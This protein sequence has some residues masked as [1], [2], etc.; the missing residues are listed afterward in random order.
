MLGFDNLSNWV[1]VPP[2]GTRLSFDG[3]KRTNWNDFGTAAW[4]KNWSINWL[5]LLIAWSVIVLWVLDILSKENVSLRPWLLSNT[6]IDDTKQRNWVTGWWFGWCKIRSVIV[7]DVLFRI[8]GCS[9]TNDRRR[10]Y[11]HQSIYSCHVWNKTYPINLFSDCNTFSSLI[12]NTL[13]RDTS[14][15]TPLSQTPSYSEDMTVS[16]VFIMPSESVLFTIWKMTE[17]DKGNQRE[18]NLVHSI[19]LIVTW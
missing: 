7:M 10:R 4:N 5:P 13:H 16:K 1:K 9:M 15:L 19:R 2:N 12:L 8:S 6:I 17:N 14:F 18:P 11:F 3:A